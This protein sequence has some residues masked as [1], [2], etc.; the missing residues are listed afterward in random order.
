MAQLDLITYMSEKKIKK[1]K[2]SCGLWLGHDMGFSDK[3]EKSRKN[4]L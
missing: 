2:I 4:R 1:K 3:A